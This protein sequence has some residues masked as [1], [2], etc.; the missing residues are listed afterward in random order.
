MQC[1]TNRPKGVTQDKRELIVALKV[2]RK[3]RR[4]HG[5]V[6]ASSDGKAWWVK[7]KP[8]RGNSEKWVFE[9]GEDPNEP[10]GACGFDGFIPSWPGGITACV[11]PVEFRDLTVA[12]IRRALWP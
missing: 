10:D 3:T 6:W 5:D 11:L 4:S 2:L 12:E 9:P 1:H 7:E 8:E